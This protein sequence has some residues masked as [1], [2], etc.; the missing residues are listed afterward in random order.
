MAM[1][2]L[3]PQTNGAGTITNYLVTNTVSLVS[4]GAIANSLSALDFG[5]AA[6][7]WELASGN[8]ATPGD[9]YMLINGVSV[10]STVIPE[11]GTWAAA[12]L[13]LTGL[14]AKLFRNRRK[15]ASA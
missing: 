3:A 9:N 13:L 6:I 4:G 5:T 2:S 12:G 10:L 11:P 8:I 1:S 15:A 7:N 14:A